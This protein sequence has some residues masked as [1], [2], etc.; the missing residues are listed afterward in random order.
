M[1]RWSKRQDRLVTWA[2]NHG[3]SVFFNNLLRMFFCSWRIKR[4]GGWSCRFSI[5]GYCYFC[6]NTLLLIEINLL[7]HTIIIQVPRAVAVVRA[8]GKTRLWVTNFLVAPYQIHTG[9]QWRMRCSHLLKSAASRWGAPWRRASR[10]GLWRR[11]LRTQ[12][13]Q[14]KLLSNSQLTFLENSKKTIEE[15]RAQTFLFRG[16]QPTG[17]KPPARNCQNPNWKPKTWKDTGVRTK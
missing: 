14:E 6:G 15:P 12:V 4:N 8:D 9:K 17:Q 2:G 3:M 1:E 5:N 10:R 7:A 13:V 16:S 11:A